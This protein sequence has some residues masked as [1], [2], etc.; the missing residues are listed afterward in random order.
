M[1]KQGLFALGWH[2]FAAT[3]VSAWAYV[4]AQMSFACC[5]LNGQWRVGQKVVR[6]VH[7]AL[8]RGFLVLLN[9]HVYTP[10]N[11]IINVIAASVKTP[12]LPL[13]QTY[14]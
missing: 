7:T 3:V 13:K 9:G 4:V 10:N 6:T 2:N 11:Y 12:D 14:R 5:W 8:G 1:A